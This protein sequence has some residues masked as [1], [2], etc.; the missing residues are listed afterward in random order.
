MSV[1][2]RS[3]EGLIRRVNGI[4]DELV[5][6]YC[7]PYAIT[8]TYWSFAVVFVYLGAQKVLPHRSSADV[9]LAVLGGIIGVPYIPFVAFVGIWQLSIGVAFF[10]RRLRLA[11][12]LFFLYQFF[13]FGSLV[14][15]RHVVF[16]PP[17]IPAFGVELPW[18]VGVYAA[19][20]LKNVVFAGIFFVLAALEAEP[21]EEVA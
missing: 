6:R 8:L 1:A 19:F 16:Q 18:A 9:Q 7:V 21:F 5:R 11:G 2:V 13:A 20:I 12:M 4:Q 17:Y 14:L 15:L 10:L 3:L